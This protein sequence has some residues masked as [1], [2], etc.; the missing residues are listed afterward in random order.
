MCMVEMIILGSM[1]VQ[2]WLMFYPSVVNEYCFSFTIILMDNL[3]F[4][5]HIHLCSIGFTDQATKL[6]MG[7]GLLQSA[8]AALPYS[9]I[10]T[11]KSFFEFSLI[12]FEPFLPV[13]FLYFD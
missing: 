4:R 10:N 11:F 6:R 2:V 3:F 9:T 8:P 12:P 1:F 13:A 5:Y 7:V